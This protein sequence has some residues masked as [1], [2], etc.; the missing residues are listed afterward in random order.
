MAALRL[1]SAPGTFPSPVGSASP[2][3]ALASGAATK[4]VLRTGLSACTPDSPIFVDAIAPQLALRVEYQYNS[5]KK[6]SRK[7][8]GSSG[9]T[10]RTA[11]GNG[12]QTRDLPLRVDGEVHQHGPVRLDPIRCHLVLGHRIG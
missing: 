6:M 10:S 11:S 12:G 3:A 7:G 8:V 1:I 5:I 2:G 4:R 9:M